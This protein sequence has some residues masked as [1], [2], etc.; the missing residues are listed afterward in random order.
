MANTT[1]GTGVSAKND[2]SLAERIEG[3]IDRPM[4]NAVAMSTIGPSV[5]IFQNMGEILEF[6]KIMA[7]AGTAIPKHLRN[8]PGACVAISLQAQRWEM[9]PF[10]VAGKSYEVN[11]RI[12]YESQLIAAVV[13]TR[14]PLVERLRVKFEG[15]GAKRRCIVSGTLIGEEESREVESPEIGSITTKNSPLWKS[16][17]DQ[18]LSYYTKRTWA[19]R[20]VPEVLLGVYDIDEMRAAEGRRGPD[21][22]VDITPPRPARAD[23]DRDT[24]EALRTQEIEALAERDRQLAQEQADETERARAAGMAV[25]PEEG[26]GETEEG[27]GQGDLLDQDPALEKAEAIIAAIGKTS[28]AK[29]VDAYLKAESKHIEAMGPEL[30]KRITAAAEARKA[31]LEAGA[32]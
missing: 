8:N 10:A 1:T 26:E 32:S 9:D 17:P 16:D 2:A 4:T 30:Q 11:D 24:P 28:A 3:K 12:A 20:E 21:R 18:Q 15:E 5:P 31:E 29:V 19:R 25:E 14:A 13:N 23:Y 22:A 7:I 6:A 27:E